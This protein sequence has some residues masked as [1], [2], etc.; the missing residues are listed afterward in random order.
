M[1]KTVVLLFVILVFAFVFTSCSSGEP[2]TAEALWEKIDGAMNALDS[3][4]V[5]LSM[6][7]NFFMSGYEVSGKATGTAIEAGVTTDDYYFYQK[8]VTKVQCDELDLNENVTA[9]YGYNEGLAFVSNEGGG[10]EQKLCA[11]MTREEFRDYV[12]DSDLN[13]LALNDCTGAEFVK[14]EDNTWSLTYSGYTKVAVNALAEAFGIDEETSDMIGAEVLDLKV[15]ISADENFF[16]K[17]MDV[18]FI[19]DVEEDEVPV[20]TATAEY[21]EYN[22]AKRIT[23]YIKPESYNQIE[24][25]RLPENIGEMLKARE[26]A[27]EGTFTLDLD[28]TV[29][30][31]GNKS[32]YRE[33]D[34]V[35]Y[36]RRDG[37]Y[38]YDIE[39][40]IKG[41]TVDITYENG[42][43]KVTQN[44]ETSTVSQTAAEAKEFI[45]SLINSANYNKM[46]VTNVTKVEEGVYTI[47]MAVVNTAVY[48]QVMTKMGAFLSSAKQ[49]ITVTIKDDVLTEIKSTVDADGY[50]PSGNSRYGVGLTVNTTVTFND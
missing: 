40:E 39:A 31:M 47:E 13:D 18:E 4:E 36:G 1:K 35:N 49:N 48:E 38:F 12:S 30:V 37:G 45:E 15:S 43:Q 24:D 46:Y 17:R 19:F 22:T 25:L 11:P 10:L 9:I 20:I 7:M 27:E 14:N 44:G 23:G 41:S 3:Y 29:M 5:D 16:V 34:K 21:S 8:M 42:K 50:I 2:E 28:Q 26:D 32:S 33:T 6:K